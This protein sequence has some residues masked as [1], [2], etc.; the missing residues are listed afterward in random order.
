METTTHEA[1]DVADQF[2]NYA[3]NL[4]LNENKSSY[5]TKAKLVEQGLSTEI[6][7]LIVENLE[8]QI[9]E[10]QYEKAR[11]DMVYGALWFC[12]GTIL[13]FADIGFIFWGAILFGGIQFFKGVINVYS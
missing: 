6:A 7:G 9:Q 3:A 13:T 11:K 8:I 5:E 4:L 10:A 2:Y 12:G 1:E